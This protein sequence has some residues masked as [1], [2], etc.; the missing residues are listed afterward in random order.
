[1]GVHGGG[2]SL[3][4][5]I[6]KRGNMLNSN[7]SKYYSWRD[8]SYQSFYQVV[9]TV[10]EDIQSLLWID[11]NK[12]KRRVKGDQLEKL[13]YS[14]EKLIRDSL[15]LVLNRN[16]IPNCPI[17]KSK[18]R[19]EGDRDDPML[20]Y[21]IFIKRAYMGMIEL[22]YLFEAEA[23]F[24]DRNP[25][26]GQF[27]QSRLTRYR[28]ESKL[29]SLFSERDRKA[30]PVIV[31]SK[32]SEP[33]VVQE[34]VKTKEGGSKKVK[35]AFED[36]DYTKHLLENLKIINETLSR[37]WYDLEIENEE[38]DRLQDKLT[39]KDR[40]DQG[41]DYILDF[42]RRSLSR[43]FNDICFET[44]GRFYGGWW[45]NIP[46]EYRAN[47]IIDGKPTVE[48]DYST[49]HPTIL[50]FKEGLSPPDDAYTQIIKENFNGLGLKTGKLRSMLKSAFNAM[51]NSKK[52]LSNSPKGITPSDFGLKWSQV[53][54]AIIKTHSP[55]AH[56]FYSDAGR[57]LQKID[58]EIAEIVLLH[59]A[60]RYIPI[61]PLHDSFIMHHHFDG[62][63]TQMM[64]KAF[65]EVVGGSINIDQK[66][67]ERL[68]SLPNKTYSDDDMEDIIDLL[69]QGYMQRETKFFELRSAKSSQVKNRA[70]G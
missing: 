8:L 55:I 59:F 23:G 7:S 11:T 14:V 10:V 67:I 25:T 57:R 68:P 51:L 2:G 28:A 40:R 31:P 12:A 37:S 38:L 13:T 64:Q 39:S 9:D 66:L 70:N 45:Q 49:I 27:S 17:A 62:E 30:F 48:F 42:G 54:K 34:K 65:N 61:L 35:L 46:K 15:A 16:K 33:L 36:S 69:A 19:Y 44:G 1:M 53:S 26:K 20:T 5:K 6:P 21:D 50:Y 43:V 63:L 41:T 22:G 4:I 47:I 29:I 56:H 52:A 18:M 32:P 60:K 24:N 58:S 3:L